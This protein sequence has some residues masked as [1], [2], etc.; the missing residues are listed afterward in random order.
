MSPHYVECGASRVG[1]ATQST[2]RPSDAG[3]SILDAGFSML[4]GVGRFRP[5]GLL[6]FD[7]FFRSHEH[8]IL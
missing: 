3:F 2:I 6:R 8:F 5:G 7:S 1:Y 4:G